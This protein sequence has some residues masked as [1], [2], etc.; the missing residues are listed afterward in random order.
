M[1]GISLLHW[2]ILILIHRMDRAAV[3]HSRAS[4]ALAGM[5]VAGAYPA[6]RTDRLVGDR[7]FGLTVSIEGRAGPSHHVQRLTPIIPYPY[8][9]GRSALL[10]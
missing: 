3:A 1:N 4:R 7:L 5:G 10:C 6:A 9:L 2:L 8:Q